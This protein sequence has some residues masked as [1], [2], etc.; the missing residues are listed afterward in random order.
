MSLVSKEG[1]A[2]GENSYPSL[3]SLLLLLASLS[4]SYLSKCCARSWRNS[5]SNV[6]RRNLKLSPL[7]YSRDISELRQVLTKCF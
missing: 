7:I 1:S 3:S 2:T 4:F 5:G 6:Q